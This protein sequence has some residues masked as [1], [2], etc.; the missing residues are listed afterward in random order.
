MPTPFPPKSSSS[1]PPPNPGPAVSA[2]PAPAPPRSRT[3]RTSFSFGSSA[4]AKAMSKGKAS[5]TDSSD[6][7]GKLK[8]FFNNLSHNS[9]GG[10][11]SSSSGD[12]ASTSIGSGEKQKADLGVQVLQPKPDPGLP[13]SQLGSSHTH[14]S[15]DPP[16]SDPMKPLPLPPIPPTIETTPRP[17]QDLAPFQQSLVQTRK[18]VTGLQ[19]VHTALT[20]LLTGLKLGTGW[21]PMVA[22][23]VDVVL[24]LVDAA[25]AVGVGKVAA[26]RLVERSA[27]VLAAVEQSIIDVKGQVSVTTQANLTKLIESLHGISYLLTKLASRSFLKLYLHADDAAAEVQKASDNLEDCVKL[28][29]LQSLISIAAWQ[30]ESKEDHER[31]MAILLKKLDAGRDSDQAMLQ[32]LEMKNDEQ[33]E[34]IKTLQR[35]L[36]AMLALQQAEFASHHP[37]VSGFSSMWSV[38]TSGGTASPVKLTAS[39]LHPLPPVRSGSS[40][41]ARLLKSSMAT[42]SSSETEGSAGRAQ[43]VVAQYGSQTTEDTQTS[44][45]TEDTQTSMP[46]RTRSTSLSSSEF[47]NHQDFCRK[48]LDVLRRNS[49]MSAGDVPDDHQAS[50]SSTPRSR[51]EYHNSQTNFSTIFAGKWRGQIVA[52]KELNANADRQLFIKEVDVWRRLRSPYILPFFGAS[53]TTGPPPWFLVSPYMKNG[54]VLEW[55][56]TPAGTKVDKIALIHQISMG[57][58][59]LHSRDIIHGDFKAINVLVDDDNQAIICDFGLSHLKMDLTR[60][61]ASSATAPS[62]LSGTMRWQAPERLAGGPL[63]TQCDVYA[64]AMSVFELYDQSES[65]PFGY[66]DDAIVKNNVQKSGLRPPRPPNVPDELWSLV[67]RCWA[68]DPKARP[69]FEAIQLRLSK[70]YKAPI[71]N[72]RKAS[73]MSTTTV[74]SEESY[75]TA[76]EDYIPPEQRAISPDS[77]HLPLPNEESN[78][79]SSGSIVSI[80]PHLENQLSFESDRAERQYRHYLTH[81]FDDRLTIPLWF[82][83]PVHLGAIGYLRHGA[84]VNLMDARVP[85]MG[86]DMPPQPFLDEFSS[87]QTTTTPVAVRSTAE[88]GLDLISGLT[89]FR[90]VSGE[91]MS[92]AISRRISFP[93]KIGMK[94]ASLIVDDGQFEIYRSFSEARAYLVANIDW[95]LKRFGETHHIVKEDVIFVVGALSATNYAMIVSNFAPRTTLTFNVH[96]QRPV[97]DPWGTWTIETAS[98]SSVRLGDN[99]DDQLGIFGPR[100]RPDVDELELKYNCKVSKV[101]Q[102]SH[103]DTVLLAKLKFPVGGSDPGLYA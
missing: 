53:S 1:P 95:I 58:E 57:L 45:T 55:L 72:E 27:T 90:K 99:S 29:Q 39:E 40:A 28:F 86:R 51:T 68:Q 26:L 59:Y 56:R 46:P 48:A 76:N 81:S 89:K 33:Q 93:L 85:P 17:V 82:P 98:S 16:H 52:I 50:V 32:M 13:S 43:S 23:G 70:M 2:H 103:K 75:E 97:N 19:T 35:T 21:L 94:H 83:S 37:A 78:S 44:Q 34:A 65:A 5:T 18:A 24:G 10:K 92:K 38:K 79:S 54:N 41:K 36:D 15:Y 63:T 6:D 74:S 42:I 49:T 87:L 61:S 77:S 9:K 8:G 91:T 7:G 12:K 101:P 66:V 73:L 96:A 71:D 84:F 3:P 80:P 67:E 20:I 31:D 14:T 11:S 47:D 102:Q 25:T 30:E 100:N 4:K 22:D 60:R 64:F 69:S 88:K 62:P